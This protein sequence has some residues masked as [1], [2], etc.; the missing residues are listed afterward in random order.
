VVNLACG[1][2]YSLLEL[3]Q[4]LKAYAGVEVDPEF[5]PP[6]SGDV[7]HSKADV[8]KARE[9]L[10]FSAQVPFSEGLERTYDWYR[11]QYR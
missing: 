11:S 2:S 9:L 5:A 6:R 4:T 7:R 8:S 3:L 1:G 10:D